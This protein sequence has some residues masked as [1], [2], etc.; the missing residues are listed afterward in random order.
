MQNR[1]P[2]KG[3]NGR[4]NNESIDMEMSDEDFDAAPEFQ[5]NIHTHKCHLIDKLNFCVSILGSN[6]PESQDGSH[7]STRSLFGSPPPN[8]SNKNTSLSGCNSHDMLQHAM[9]AQPLMM[10][11][12]PHMSV[13][14]APRPLLDIP[15]GFTNN[16]PRPFMHD[17]DRSTIVVPGANANHNPFLL[18]NPRNPTN[19]FMNTFRGAGPLS[20]T[21]I[22]NNSPYNRIPRGNMRGGFRHNFRGGNMRGNW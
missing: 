3:Q 6:S 11:Q 20:P 16:S 12:S 10:H 13:T 4:D 7:T 14:R 9:S 1:S 15:I 5:S 21:I 19:P 22:R 8:Y 2:A 18:N 17:M